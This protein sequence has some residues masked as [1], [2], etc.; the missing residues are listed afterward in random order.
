MRR[1]GYVTT[2]SIA[3]LLSSSCAS[4]VAEREIPLATS[5]TQLTEVEREPRHATTEVTGFL[6][7]EQNCVGIFDT[8]SEE[9]VAVTWPPGWKAYETDRGGVRVVDASGHE[10]V[11]SG[12]GFTAQG[13]ALEG[14]QSDACRAVSQR[15]I[16]VRSAVDFSRTP[17][18]R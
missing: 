14:A 1:L 12:R 4:Q 7:H 5:A 9:F 8:F 10:V 11:T 17:E 13:V 3:V 16:S 15:G 6:T 18:L 2:A